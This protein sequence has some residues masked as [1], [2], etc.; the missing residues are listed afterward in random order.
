MKPVLPRRSSLGLDA[1]HKGCGHPRLGMTTPYTPADTGDGAPQS[2]AEPVQ[3]DPRD[4]HILLA[5]VAG[6]REQQRQPT[7]CAEC[8]GESGFPPLTLK[9]GVCRW[10]SRSQGTILALRPP[11]ECRFNSSLLIRALLLRQPGS[12]SSS[13]CRRR[14]ASLSM[15][16]SGRARFWFVLPKHSRSYRAVQWCL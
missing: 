13:G 4:R 1:D 5:L 14:T 2:L 15:H 8:E 10:P 7:E 16:H 12:R 3:S 11:G 6:V 9:K